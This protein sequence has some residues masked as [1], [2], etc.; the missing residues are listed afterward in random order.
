MTSVNK[1][2]GSV[3]T[4][5]VGPLLLV[6]VSLLVAQPASAQLQT[7]QPKLATL[8]LSAGMHNIVAEVAATPQQRQIGMMMRTQMAQHEGMLFVFEQ[9]T[10]QCF[11]MRNTLLPLAIAFLADD[12]RIVNLAE[13]QAQTDDSHC[14]AEPVRYV[15]EMNKGWFD[16]RGIKAGVRL[17][18]K[19]FGN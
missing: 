4:V 14:S 12:G 15:L 9:P 7:P 3:L 13:M 19:P 18:G 10:R 8:T 5:L 11:W 17:R 2:L 1:P 6:F 16:K